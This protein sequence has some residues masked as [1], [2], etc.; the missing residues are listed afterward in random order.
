MHF[1]SQKKLQGEVSLSDTLD[2][3]GEGNAL[4]LMDV[5]SVDDDMLENLDARDSCIQVRK[6]VEE[7][8]EEREKMIITMRYGLDNK[9][10]RTQREI[11]AESGISRSY[12]SRIEK[13]ALK[14]LKDAMD[15]GI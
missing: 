15:G 8:L 2:S 9:P 10:P 5:I 1:R 11:A 7:C 14:K 3:D 12:V 13:K 4:S 6:L